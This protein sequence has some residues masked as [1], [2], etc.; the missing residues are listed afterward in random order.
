MHC[1]VC[2]Q[3]ASAAALGHLSRAS[4]PVSRGP[5]RPTAA[6]RRAPAAELRLRRSR[7]AA[8]N[9][10][11]QLR[12]STVAQRA[13]RRR[14][15]AAAGADHDNAAADSSD[16]DAF[17]ADE[18]EPVLAPQMCTLLLKK[19]YGKVLGL[20]RVF[21]EQILLAQAQLDPA[22]EDVEACEE[23]L[24][25]CKLLRLRCER[26]G[27]AEGAKQH[28][29]ELACKAKLLREAQGR[30]EEIIATGVHHV[31]MRDMTAQ[32]ER[33]LRNYKMLRE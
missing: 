9:V 25:L 22:K 31:K 5:W 24:E 2:A 14:I 30:V 10:V 20:R 6:L 17:A 29:G 32:L 19:L 23:A 11:A 26:A 33:E 15:L 27:D 13:A 12:D 3:L 8:N 21:S 1:A 28:A 7:S 16:G 4:S 18:A